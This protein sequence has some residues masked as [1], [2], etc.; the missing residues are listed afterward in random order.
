[1]WCNR[2]AMSG[3]SRVVRHV[4]YRSQSHSMVSP[5]AIGVI[6]HTPTGGAADSGGVLVLHGTGTGA[7]VDRQQIW[8]LDGG[9]DNS[10]GD[11]GDLPGE[12]ADSEN[13]GAVMP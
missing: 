7:P 2:Q 11:L 8:T 1:M 10:G 13:F 5:L 4:M 3:V 12:P 6:A 9:R